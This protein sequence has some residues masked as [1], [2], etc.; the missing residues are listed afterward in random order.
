MP[1]SEAAVGL[2]ETARIALPILVL[3]TRNWRAM[4]RMMVTART[5][6]WLLEMV[7]N[8]RWKVLA[9]NIVGNARGV[10]FQ[11]SWAEFCKSSDT[12]MAVMRT[13]SFELLRKGR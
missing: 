8:W 7:T 13:F 6:I 1:T 4:R 2:K 3:K 9:G 11:K 10:A 12:P 5:T